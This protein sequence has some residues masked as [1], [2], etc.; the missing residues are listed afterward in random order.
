MIWVMIIVFFVLMI[1]GVPIAFAMGLSSILFMVV[2][3]IP[4][5]MVA[6]R[7]FS[8]TQSF[9]FLAVPFFILAGTMMVQGGIARRIIKLA[10]SIV[11]PLPGGLALVS[12]VTSMLMAGVSGSS[13][14]DASGV[15]SI[16]IPA[17]KE[18]GYDA[19]FSAVINATTS[20]VG[21]IIPP[22]S[23]MVILAWITN[24]SVAR[25][26][27]GG[28]IPGILISV[29]FFII[30]IFISI[31][32]GY[33]RGGFASIKEILL[34]IKDSIWALFLPFIILGGIIFGV[35]TVTEIAAVS[36]VYAFFV[37]FVI[38]RSLNIKKTLIALRD[39]IYSTA[40]VMMIVCTSTIFTWILIRQNI[41]SIIS[42][43]LLGLGVNNAV[44]LF[45]IILI[46]FIMGTFMDLV[47]ILFLVVP[48]FFPIAQ[49][50]GIDPIHFGVLM[51][52]T[53]AMGLFTP[54][55]GVTLFISCHLAK[56]GIEDVAKDLV[57]YF[58][59]GALI[60]LLAAYIPAITM[61]L[62]DMLFK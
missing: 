18:E 50:M 1:I 17:M 60:C 36:A 5:V 24:L 8:N 49:G 26:F 19:P 43:A 51:I 29:I 57:P 4:L 22:S 11:R 15:G 47:P 28:A 44:L 27:L 16:L 34:S 54:P 30:T 25:L 3:D 37:G 6:Q 46:M 31:K 42:S 12:V 62:P 40:V 39:S 45:I 21:I 55:V 14:A 35:A 48:I 32:R 58:L 9:P 2:E 59:G 7:F 33:P 52:L 23:T 13:A 53:G 10:D 56:V 20:V 41:P 61:W 38:Y